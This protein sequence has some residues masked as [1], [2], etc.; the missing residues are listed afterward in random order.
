M[1]GLAPS[2]RRA[3]RGYAPLVVLLTAFVAFSGLV[4][5]TGKQALVA[6]GGTSGGVVTIPGS[7]GQVGSGEV[8]AG[9]GTG[10]GGTSR[11]IGTSSACPDRTLQVPGDTY[12]P[13]CV[14]FSGDNG[15]ATA[16]GVTA[17]TIKAT[18]R[19][20]SDTETAGA[21]QAAVGSGVDI[22]DT[23]E[24]IKR[25]I[26]GLTEFFNSNYQFYGRKLAV[27]FFDGRGSGADEL[28]GGGQDAANADAVTV[29]SEKGAF[30]DPSAGTPPYTD[31]LARRGVIAVG[32]DYL[33]DEWYAARHPYAWGPISCSQAF[34]Q[35]ADYA[36]KRIFGGNADH[37]GDGLQGKPRKIG[38]IS[39]ENSYYQDC[40]KTF[41]KD[42]A[43]RGHKLDAQL[44]YA[45]DINTV[46]QDTSS[47]IARLS[48]EGITTVLCFTDPISPLFYT[49]KATQQRYFPEWIVTGVAATDSDIAGQQYDQQQWQHAFGIRNLSENTARQ[50][51]VAYAAFKKA[52]P[53]EE[54][55]GLALF[56]IYS[57]L[58][59]TAL[60]IQ[61]AGPRLTPE[62]FAAGWQSYPGGT[63]LGGKWRGQAGDHTFQVDSQEVYWD[64]DR[65]SGFNNG[66]GAYVPTTPRYEVGQ[67]PVGKPQVFP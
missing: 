26:S 41:V 53:N 36:S 48:A 12:S 28:T 55:A 4:P 34:R 50:A 32:M 60:A 61:G 2:P 30:L 58:L 27:D 22:T 51:S 43:A 62:T 54:P 65:I 46:S 6:S 45:L 47:I 37:A 17:N 7:A 10:P 9:G 14:A 29:A 11:R 42:L 67:W 59:Q 15:G 23:P 64:K 24:D 16:K 19:F 5:T 49:A 39:P 13:P 18:W 57:R 35:M 20:T 8:I 40:V 63:G 31:A 33:S 21:I 25:T 56:G 1:S 66:R 38:L 52:R 3:V 44:T